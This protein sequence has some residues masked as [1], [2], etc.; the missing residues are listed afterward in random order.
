MRPT[1]FR[2]LANERRCHMR[3]R[4]ASKAEL[5]SRRPD[6]CVD[7][8][9]RQGRAHPRSQCRGE[10]TNC[11][12][13]LKLVNYCIARVSSLPITGQACQSVPRNS[14]NI[15]EQLDKNKSTGRGSARALTSR[16][17]VSAIGSRNSAIKLLS[18]D[19]FLRSCLTS[20]MSVR[21]FAGT[22]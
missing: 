2:R 4:C 9:R 20:R 6:H 16:R 8:V 11:A 15:E 14:G 12:K 5:N 22:L 3:Q 10:S 7:S 19:K 18:V 13:T 1:M 17:P 21:W